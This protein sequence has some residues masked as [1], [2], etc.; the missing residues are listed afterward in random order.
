VRHGVGQRVSAFAEPHLALAIAMVVRQS[1]TWALC[2]ANSQ[3]IASSEWCN[4]PV[5]R[6]H[7]LIGRI[8][9]RFTGRR[10]SWGRIDYDRSGVDDDGGHDL[11][12]GHG[13]ETVTGV[14]VHRDRVTGEAERIEMARSRSARRGVDGSGVRSAGK[15]GRSGWR[16]IDRGRREG[17][18]R[19]GIGSALAPGMVIGSSV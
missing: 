11:R 2:M 7:A 18:D 14:E 3:L 1:P 10:R 13:V 19:R 8:N 12:E 4:G 9:A 17:E 6:V 5:W 16:G 15:G